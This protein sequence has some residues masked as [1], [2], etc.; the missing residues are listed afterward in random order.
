MSTINDSPKSEVNE[1]HDGFV[2]SQRAK[3]IA[4]FVFALA[5]AVAQYG[6]ALAAPIEWQR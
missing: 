4:A 6:S 1:V 3:L 5:L 2:W